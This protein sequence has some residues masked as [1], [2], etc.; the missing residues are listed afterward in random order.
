MLIDSH[1]HLHAKEWFSPSK[2][3]AALKYARV[4]GVEKIICIGTDHKDSL[5]A[6]DFAMAHQNVYWT[7]GIHPENADRTMEDVFEQ[8]HGDLRGGGAI[9]V[10]EIGL[11]YHYAGCNRTAQ[12][13]LLERMLQLAL[14]Q[15]LPVSLHIREAFDDAYAVLDNFSGITGVVHSFTGSKK[16]LRQALE[17][18]FMIGINGLVTY[19]TPPLPPLENIVLETDAP[20]LTPVPFRG[21]INEP[22]YIR[23]IAVYLAAKMG[24][25]IEVIEERTTQNARRIFQI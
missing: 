6:R 16:N 9:A 22:A 11:D 1:C 15:E 14:D 2:A 7:Y 20:F 24:V 25:A 23:E 21:T 17:R 18:G 10:G 13:K 19:T 12:I 3:E 5:A 8:D 4:A